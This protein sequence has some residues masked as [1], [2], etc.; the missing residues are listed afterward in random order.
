[1][2]FNTLLTA[3]TGAAVVTAQ[4]NFIPVANKIVGHFTRVSKYAVNN[5]VIPTPG[6]LEPV[7]TRG[8]GPEKKDDEDK[9]EAIRTSVFHV[10][11]DNA[12][13]PLG[14]PS[15]GPLEKG[16]SD[17]L[18]DLNLMNIGER[19]FDGRHR[20]PL[21]DKIT[22]NFRHNPEPKS[23]PKSSHKPESTHKPQWI[24]IGT[25]TTLWI[26]NTQIATGIRKIPLGPRETF[27][28]SAETAESTAL[29]PE[30]TAVPVLPL[31]YHPH[32]GQVHR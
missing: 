17:P 12:D 4:I 13:D 10:T 6:A 27:A 11:A 16:P 5:I 24:G 3:L 2:K 9:E 29:Q 32:S 1:M 14:E 21:L 30:V 7:A 15:I 22:D 28:A 20:I 25:H 23:E 8:I 18:S 19:S 31:G 26:P